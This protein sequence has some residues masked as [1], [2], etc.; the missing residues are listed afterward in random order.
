MNVTNQ[1]SNPLQE[2]RKDDLGM[3]FKEGLNGGGKYVMV[4]KEQ[5]DTRRSLS[6][7]A[8][9]DA[10]VVR[11][12]HQ[13][14]NVRLGDRGAFTIQAEKIYGLVRHKNKWASGIL[15]LMP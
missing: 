2:A 3:G 14:R 5:F 10:R 4:D 8:S 7:F 15:F 11:H 12:V 1:L 9:R 6:F 13:V